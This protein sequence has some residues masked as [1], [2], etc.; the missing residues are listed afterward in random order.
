MCADVLA[1]FSL[2]F[3]SSTGGERSRFKE[4]GAL[5]GNYRETC[6]H[7]NENSTMIVRRAI[8]IRLI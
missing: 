8:N 4:L 7:E 3:C 1:I 6:R 5:S 2:P